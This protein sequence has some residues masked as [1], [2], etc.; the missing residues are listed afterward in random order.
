[1]TVGELRMHL[2]GY[3]DGEWLNVVVGF[4]LLEQEGYGRVHTRTTDIVWCPPELAEDYVNDWQPA[5]LLPADIGT[6]SEEEMMRLW[7]FFVDWKRGNDHHNGA[8]FRSG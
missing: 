5:L 3:D 8:A 2:E 6:L 1:M 4:P 7:R